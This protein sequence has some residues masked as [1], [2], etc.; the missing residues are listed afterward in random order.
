M[1]PKTTTQKKREIACASIEAKIRMALMIYNG[2][3]AAASV[4][5][6]SSIAEN[7]G[8]RIDGSARGQ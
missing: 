5:R 8:K 6:L 2:M 1:Q 4:G 7:A 3:A